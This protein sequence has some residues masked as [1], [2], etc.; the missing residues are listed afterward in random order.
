M[1]NEEA[2]ARAAF[3]AEAL[4][5][6]G[7]P[8]R[9]CADVKGPNGAV[10]CAMLLVRCA[11]D[12]GRL[13]PFDPRPYSPRWHLHRSEEKFVGWLEQLG[14]RE[15]ARPQVGDIVLWRFGRVFS[16][17]A[18]LVGRDEIVHAYYA[19][20]QVLVSKLH[21]PLLDFISVGGLNIPRPVK[22]FD[23]WGG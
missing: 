3:V 19:A 9:D 13:P 17:G 14:A 4:S 11:V 15:V 8:F 1:T 5:W 7:T 18:V 12:T 16:H 22:Y 6:V 23:L 21:E 10:D 20:G 2:S